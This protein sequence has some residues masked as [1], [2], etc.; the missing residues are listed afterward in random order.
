M[1]APRGRGQRH[2]VRI[3]GGTFV[4]IDES[5]NASPA[6]MTAAIETLGQ[7]RPG[8]GGRRVAV[9]G[10]MLE[11]GPSAAERHAALATVL[12]KNGV[13]LVFTVGQHMAH[14]W[15][16]LPKS[17]R[18]GHAISAEKLAPIVTGAARSGD[19]VVVKGSAGSRTGQI[20][21]A[22]LAFDADGNRPVR[23]HAVNGNGR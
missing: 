18:G 10:D 16:A 17:L 6:S 1:N 14:L 15:D 7:T 2:T 9:L 22:L 23:P 20:V 11:L 21:Q 12:V 13:D 4:L 3:P 19:V 5:Y 8:A